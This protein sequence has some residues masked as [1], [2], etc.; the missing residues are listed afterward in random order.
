MITNAVYQRN[1]TV[2]E[3]LNMTF[4]WIEGNSDYFGFPEQVEKLILAQDNSF[5]LCFMESQKALTQSAMGYQM[6]MKDSPYIDIEKPWWYTDLI[7]ESRISDKHLYYISGAFAMTTFL[8]AGAILFNKPRW[9]STFGD[10]ENLYNMVREENW[11]FDTMYAA[12]RDVYQDVNGN[13]R[14]TSTIFTA[15]VTAVWQA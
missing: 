5:D 6:D 7:K 4:E 13:G 11:T 1:L 12:C 10:T 2:E 9:E 8:K 15:S 14:W 3:N